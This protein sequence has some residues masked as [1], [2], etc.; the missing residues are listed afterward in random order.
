METVDDL[1]QPRNGW[2]GDKSW[3]LKPQINNSFDANKLVSGDVVYFEYLNPKF[4]VKITE[5]YLGT[6][7]CTRTRKQDLATKIVH[8]QYVSTSSSEKP[9]QIPLIILNRHKY[10]HRFRFESALQKYID[11][12]VERFDF[13]YE[14]YSQIWSLMSGNKDDVKLACTGIMNVDW[15][16]NKFLFKFLQIYFS[17][18]LCNSN[19]GQLPGW[20]LFAEVNNVNWKWLNTAVVQLFILLKEY[21]VSTEEITLIRKLLNSK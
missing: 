12:K 13:S 2:V 14:K 20:S 18:V 4:S 10:Y 15:S 16:Q 1:Y 8:N 5:E 11:S 21:E 3:Q 17:E 7:G 19:L 9:V 6:I